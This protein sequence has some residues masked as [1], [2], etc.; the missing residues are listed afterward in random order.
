VL[1]NPTNALKLTAIYARVSTARQ[2]EEQTIKTQLDAVDE[3]VRKSDFKV[4]EQ[5][6]DEGWS[7]DMLA[8][9]GLDKLR[10]DAKTK[11][12][13][14]VVIYDPDRLA[15]RYSYQELIMDELRE[16]GIEVVFVT[17]AAPKN[18]E[19]KILHGVRGLFAEYERAKI[20][21]RFRLGKIRKIKEGHL[22]V[23]SPLYG[24]RYIAMQDKM[25]GYYEVDESEARVARMIFD[26]VDREGL[27]VRGIVRKLHQ[28]GVAPRKS[29]RGVWATSTLSKLLKNTAY[30]GQAHWGS[31]Y[32]VVP[33]NPKIKVRYRKIKKSSRRMKPQS[34]WYHVPVPAIIDKE[35]FMRVQER[36]RTNFLLSRRN[37]K[38][39]YLLAGRI[40]C[41]CGR[42]RG[43]EG[44]QNGKHLYY[45]CLDRTLNLP[46]PP[47]CK[48][49]SLNAR[50]TD[51]F[52]WAQVSHLMASPELL[53]EQVRQWLSKQGKNGDAVATDEGF[54]KQEINKLKEQENRYNQAFGSGLFT[55]DDLKSYLLPIREKV[56]S[57][58][59]QLAQSQ[60]RLLDLNA[61]PLPSDAEIE[62]FARQATG[63]L[64]NLG[65][66]ERKSIIRHVVDKVVGSRDKLQIHG[67]IPLTNI[68]VCTNDRHR[69]DIPRHNLNE[70]INVQTNHRYRL[71]TPR[72]NSADNGS[73]AI[74]FYI[75]IEVPQA[76]V[77]NIKNSNV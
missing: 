18:S 67:F 4:V 38:N 34:E 37:T 2:E 29:K 30:I 73:N 70:N 43:G 39:Q 27:T 16:A 32:A 7:G 52:V 62:L 20:T 25:H 56:A 24:Y 40:Y 60:Q 55:L 21:E 12:W 35:V 65:F 76:R 17:V 58:Q 41:P 13:Q 31:S 14:V 45:R 47:I 49:K 19:E 50:L 57:Y 64:A 22:L 69:Q 77:S 44:P 8:R 28:L 23:S 36:I 15:R 63:V 75:E 61:T 54:I 46:L 74:P 1:E 66:E 26:W 5:Y 51:Q 3:L 10:D 33:E 72:H 11:R 68:N 9:P 71:D 53:K 6:V 42:K 48:E 59:S